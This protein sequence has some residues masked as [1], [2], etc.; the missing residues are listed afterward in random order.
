MKHRKGTPGNTLERVHGGDLESA[1]KRYG[2]PL[3]NW[4]DLSTGI[5]PLPYPNTQISAHS[6]TR[7]PYQQESFRRAV[8][9]YYGEYD[10][11]ATNGSQQAIMALP[12]CL[13]NLPVLL[14]DVGYQE[15]KAAWA[16]HGAELLYYPACQVE[17][18][19][20]VIEQQIA[21]ERAFH[22]L[23]INPNNPGCCCFSPVTL[24]RWARQL[25]PGSNLIVDEA[26]A[27]LEPEQSILKSGLAS[28]LES[29]MLVLRSFGKFFGL[30]GLRLG[31][32]FADSPLLSALRPR[33]GIWDVNGPAQEIATRAFRDTH[34]QTETRRR[35]RKLSEQNQSVWR[36]L[37]DQLREQGHRV[38]ESHQ[39]LFSSYTLDKE[40]ARQLYELF[41]R[42]GVLLRLVD[43]GK[44]Q[45]IIR[46]GVLDSSG[47][48]QMTSIVA[49]VKSEI[50]H[51]R[52]AL[53]STSMH[54]AGNERVER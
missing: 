35:I 26:F 44:G 9:D 40:L 52:Y 38:E 20:R 28:G 3:E 24:S 39:W 53:E 50:K 10:F 15:H 13:N 6:F 19:T 51:N 33:I 42:Q 47:I 1:C 31:F 43:T 45:A 37:F 27:D 49:S 7:M 48:E 54:R 46:T 17:Q 23:V 18:A 41:A 16:Q 5:S 11:L 14:P 21:A 29:N 30:P 12:G 36:E 22:L 32:V 25:P 8:C 2:I 34:W 4:I